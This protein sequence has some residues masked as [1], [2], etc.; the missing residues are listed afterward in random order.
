MR[1]IFSYQMEGNEIL[2]SNIYRYKNNNEDTIKFLKL[3]EQFAN[4][5]NFNN[6]YSKHKDYYQE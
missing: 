1:L 3:L 6:F 2:D 5:S 4:K